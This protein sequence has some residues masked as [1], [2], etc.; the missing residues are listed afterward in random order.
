MKVTQL[1][2]TFF[3]P[4]DYIIHGILQARILEWVAFPF[5]RGSSQPRDWTQALQADSLAAEPQGNPKILEWVAYLFSS[6]SFWSRNR[7]RVFCITS[8]FFTNRTIR[9]A[10]VIR[11]I[12]VRTTKGYLFISLG[13]L[14]LKKK[15]SINISEDVKKL[16]TLVHCCWEFKLS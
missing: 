6:R 16:E 5:S 8:R 7:T 10:P 9:K 1:C 13:S 15:K 4:M 12:Y 3:Y 14:L 2:P 11:E